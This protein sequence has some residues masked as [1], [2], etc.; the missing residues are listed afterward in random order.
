MRVR[1]RLAVKEYSEFQTEAL[2]R[3]WNQENIHIEFHLAFTS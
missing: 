1:V 2:P 3:E